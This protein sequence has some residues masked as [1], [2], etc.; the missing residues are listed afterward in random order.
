[1]LTLARLQLQ[2]LLTGKKVWLLLIFML[3]PLALTVTLV[4]GNAFRNEQLEAVSIYLFI[5]HLVA[6][7]ILLCLVYGTSVIGADVDDRTIVYLFTRSKARWEVFVGKYLAIVTLLSCCGVIDFLISWLL[8]GCPGGF[9]LAFAFV[10]AIV[11]AMFAYTAIFAALGVLFTKRAMV[12]GLLY[13]FIFEWGVSFVPAVVNKLT[14]THQLRSIIARLVEFD[15]DQLHRTALRMVGDA[16][17]VEAAIALTLI[18]GIALF[19]AAFVVTRREYSG[20][21]QS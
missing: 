21:Q 15:L 7:S 5:L 17:L 4:W 10:I 1:M 9:M 2:Q 19:H 16:S 12:V 20:A 13:A 8:L 3:L 18:T 11:A 14:V 6:F